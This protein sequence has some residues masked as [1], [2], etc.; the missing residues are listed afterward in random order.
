MPLKNVDQN[1][2]I[3]FF[4]EITDDNNYKILDIWSSFRVKVIPDVYESDAYIEYTPKSTDS[5]F[6]LSTKYYGTPKM[7]WVIPLVNDAE[8]PFDFLQ[9]IVDK[10]GTI[11]ILKNNYISS[12][13]FS[14]SRM[15]NA[16]DN[17]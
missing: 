6:M 1:S 10:S 9:N 16:K 15:K 4:P 13:L 14:V 17:S 7:W 3:N 11:K 8:D 12:I 2:F 5:L